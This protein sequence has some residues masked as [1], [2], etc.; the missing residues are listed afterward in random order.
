MSCFIQSV[1][2]VLILSLQGISDKSIVSRKHLFSVAI[3]LSA[4]PE[5]SRASLRSVVYGITNDV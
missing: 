5:I 3:I 4:V 2:F 1:L